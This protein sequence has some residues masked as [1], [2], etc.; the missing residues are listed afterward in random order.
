MSGEFKNEVREEGNMKRLVVR[1][2][3]AK[4]PVIAYLQSAGLKEVYANPN[5]AYYSTSRALAQNV[6]LFRKTEYIIAS[7]WGEV[8]TYAHMMNVVG[9]NG[10]RCGEWVLRNGGVSKEK[11]VCAHTTWMLG[12]EEGA[13]GLC[14][15]LEEYLGVEDLW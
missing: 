9:Y 15:S 2:G 11:I 8:G 3:N 13:R 7:V 14:D 6:N 5:I 1:L 10:K 4:L 12:L